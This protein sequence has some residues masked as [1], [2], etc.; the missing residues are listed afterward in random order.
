MEKERGRRDTATPDSEKE[1]KTPTSLH[2]RKM[3]EVLPGVSSPLTS[4]EKEKEG[5]E[6]EHDVDHAEEDEEKEQKVEERVPPRARNTQEDV[7]LL[8]RH[9]LDNQRDSNVPLEIRSRYT[10]PCIHASIH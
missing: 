8:S 5:Q 1:M 2:V 7:P 3:T 4:P 10:G 9:G 6:E